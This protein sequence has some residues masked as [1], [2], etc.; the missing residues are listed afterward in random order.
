MNKVMSICMDRFP[1]FDW[2]IDIH[3]QDCYN[4]TVSGSFGPFNTID[5]FT[6]AGNHKIISEF[7]GEGKWETSCDDYGLCRTI[8][9]LAHTFDYEQKIWIDLVNGNPEKDW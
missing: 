3:D 8:E 1:Q 5:V 9:D 6:E 2:V 4:T 7:G